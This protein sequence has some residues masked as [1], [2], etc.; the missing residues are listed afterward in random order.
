MRRALEGLLDEQD[1]VSHV[2]T[3]TVLLKQYT[4][5]LNPNIF[6]GS[7]VGREVKSDD[8][9]CVVI[10]KNSHQYQ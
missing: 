3:T 2:Y 8:L 9:M 4:E 1:G 10:S 5:Q 7:R 6:S